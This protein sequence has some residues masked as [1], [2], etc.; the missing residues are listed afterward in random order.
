MGRNIRLTLDAQIQYFAE[1]ALAKTVVQFGGKWGGCDVASASQ[2]LRLIGR[3]FTDMGASRALRAGGS[4]EGP[5][6]ADTGERPFL[7]ESGHR[8]GAAHGLPFAD[9]RQIGSRFVRGAPHFPRPRGRGRCDAAAAGTRA[10][11]GRGAP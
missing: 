2:R 3:T 8:S 7:H 10:L 11:G 6:S 4:V 1:D 9:F 5:A